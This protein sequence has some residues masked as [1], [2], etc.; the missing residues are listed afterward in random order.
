MSIPTETNKPDQAEVVFPAT[1]QS[2]GTNLPSL[3]V[4]SNSTKRFSNRFINQTLPRAL[5]TREGS[6][7][8]LAELFTGK[9]SASIELKSDWITPYLFYGHRLQ[10]IRLR[11]GK[12]PET[13]EYQFSGGSVDIP[14]T[15]FEA[16]Y[17]TEL[18]T[19]EYKATLQ[20]KKSF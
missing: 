6:Y 18:E 3:F 8:N 7:T 11:I 10:G 2:D 5:K 12:N 15:R 20:W 19:E 13:D 14:F 9:D 17:E 16:G 1:Y 4:Q